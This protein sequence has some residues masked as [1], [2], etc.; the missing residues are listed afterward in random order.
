MPP[1]C[2]N[3]LHGVLV[4]KAALQ[5]NP[6]SASESWRGY[7]CMFMTDS[8]EGQHTDSHKDIKPEPSKPQREN[9]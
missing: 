9:G 3:P 7:R 6:I 1:I 5:E 4:K 8:F 2:G